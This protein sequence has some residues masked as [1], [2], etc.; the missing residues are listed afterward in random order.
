MGLSVRAVNTYLDVIKS[1]A[2][3]FRCFFIYSP[4]G[5]NGGNRDIMLSEK[6]GQGKKIFAQGG[7]TSG[8][9]HGERFELGNFCGQAPGLFRRKFRYLFGR[10]IITIKAV[11]RTPAGDFPHDEKGGGKVF[12][13]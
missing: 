4:P 13:E 7:F 10:F 9:T 1:P 2:D 6:T 11:A 5:S 12:G 8:E 3:L